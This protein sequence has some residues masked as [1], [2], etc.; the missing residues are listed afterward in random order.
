[1]V[2]AVAR[3]LNAVPERQLDLFAGAGVRAEHG[4]ADPVR[5][6]LI[7]SEL[8]DG[9]LVA[10]IPQASLGDCEALA[11]EAAR[12]RSAA[13]VPALEALCRRFA[14]FGRE[15][16]IPEQ[17]AALTALAAIGGREAAAAV[18]RTIVAGIAQGPGLGAAVDAAARLGAMLPE[19]AVLP[20]LRHQDRRIRAAASR[21]ARASPAVIAALAELLDD[22]DRAVAVEAACALGLMGRG[23]ARAM[24]LRSLREAPSAEIV[25]AASGIADEECL[26]VLGRLARTRADLAQAALAALESIN[27]PRALA[28]A[29]AARRAIGT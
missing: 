21:C 25:E 11:A 20:L 29:A 1:V 7:A 24:L 12:R 15:R 22:A 14:G 6:R 27:S 8:D 2:A 16:A 4:A 17:L 9:A 19:S 3:A 23:E 5:P 13:A 10:A 26:I 18:A 28:I